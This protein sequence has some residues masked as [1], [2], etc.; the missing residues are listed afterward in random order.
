MDR[1]AKVVGIA[2]IALLV[3]L[4]DAPLVFYWLKVQLNKAEFRE[5]ALVFR[6][7][8]MSPTFFGV[9][10]LQAFGSV[11]GNEE[12]FGP[13][14]EYGSQAFFEAKPANEKW[15]VYFNSTATG[16]K[17]YDKSFRLLIRSEFDAI[18]FN[19]LWHLLVVCLP[20]ASVLAV[21]LIYFCRASK[22]KVR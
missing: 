14:R 1:R 15:W 13:W 4:L 12:G 3:L 20:S 7:L 21:A 9:H 22:G 19:L 11:D 6:E 16:F 18:S 17:I 2:L 5:R 10:S 8:K